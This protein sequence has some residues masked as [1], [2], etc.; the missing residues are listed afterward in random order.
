MKERQNK[1]KRERER[2]D[3]GP[4]K[5][6]QMDKVTK[7]LVIRTRGH[8]RIE[9]EER[10]KRNSA[11]HVAIECQCPR[12]KEGLFQSVQSLFFLCMTRT[13]QAGKELS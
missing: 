5:T 3:E 13:A 2:E 6:L 11:I 1:R 8:T 4:K 12:D 10:K 9:V 7:I